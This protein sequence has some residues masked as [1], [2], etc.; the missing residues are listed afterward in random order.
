MKVFFDECFGFRVPEAFHL[1]TQCETLR[2]RKR[3][4]D[5]NVK[6]VTWLPVIGAEGW[7]IV[8]HNERM[9][10]I[11]KER[12]AIIENT[13][14]VVFVRQGTTTMSE[15]LIFLLRRFE[16]LQEIDTLPRPFAFVTS[17]RGRPRKIDLEAD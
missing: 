4:P 13:A 17:V 7:L 9:L 8:S 5:N 3:F 14:G 6:D 12:S 16:W 10:D 1:V 2:L 11:E 15:K